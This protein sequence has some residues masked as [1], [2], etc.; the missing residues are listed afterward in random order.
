MTVS[1][2]LLLFSLLPGAPVRGG[3]PLGRQVAR[4]THLVGRLGL[5]LVGGFLGR[6]RAAHDLALRVVGLGRGRDL[7]EVEVGA[8][9]CVDLARADRAFQQLDDLAAQPVLERHPVGLGV[10]RGERVGAGRRGRGQQ[11]AGPVD[12][13][14]RVGL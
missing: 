3:G 9:R 7:V 12:Q 8:D 14:D 4:G 2:V 11:V 5:L 10:A 1:S 13:R 6:L